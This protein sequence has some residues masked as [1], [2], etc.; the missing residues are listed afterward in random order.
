MAIFTPLIIL[1]QLLHPYQ[2]GLSIDP[3]IV[4]KT[5]NSRFYLKQ[6]A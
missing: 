5:S 4:L 6:A 3:A 1:N 2:P